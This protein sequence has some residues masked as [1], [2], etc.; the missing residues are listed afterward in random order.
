MI[1][2]IGTNNMFDHNLFLSNKIQSSNNMLLYNN[3]V[4]LTLEHHYNNI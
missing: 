4:F 2:R 1:G 3:I